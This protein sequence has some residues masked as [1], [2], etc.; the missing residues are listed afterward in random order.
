MLDD[1][2][3]AVSDSFDPEAVAALKPISGM[4]TDSM[5][6]MGISTVL[7]AAFLLV[8][9]MVP[10]AA[11]DL[12]LDDHSAQDRFVQ[13]L[14]KPDKHETTANF[15]MPEASTGGG[16]GATDGDQSDQ[17]AQAAEGAGSATDIEEPPG[18]PDAPSD[19]VRDTEIARDAGLVGVFSENTTNMWSN[20]ANSVG[21]GAMAALNSIEGDGAIG[22]SEVGGLGI[23]GDGRGDSDG[24]SIIG[25]VDPDTGAGCCGPG[26]EGTGG[27]PTA[28]LGDKEEKTREIDVTTD[29]PVVC[30]E[31][32]DGRCPLDK[33]MI[34]RVVRKHRR[35]LAYCY[36]KSLQT[37]RGL[38]GT[39]TVNFSIAAGGQVIA[40]TVEKSSLGSTQVESC[41][42]GKI[43]HWNFP[44]HGM[45]LAK[46]RYPFRFTPSGR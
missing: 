17:T 42:T 26:G 43:R 12:E 44:P 41:V 30:G 32:H 24:D 45:A 31:G 3:D 5:P 37:R 20:D 22:D 15:A 14:Q 4:D 46:V 19:P 35:E 1:R 7:H 38:E 8:A 39:V 11:A 10:A 34:R 25:G 33:E 2:F 23:R 40:A 13:L 29:G 6:Y 16:G 27:P 28:D 36:E 21:A 18:A 9:M